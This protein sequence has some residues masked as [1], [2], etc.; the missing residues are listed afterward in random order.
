MR[1]TAMIA[2]ALKTWISLFFCLPVIKIIVVEKFAISLNKENAND[3]I[4]RLLALQAA[5][6]VV[7]FQS[8]CYG[9]SSLTKE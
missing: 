8:S 5:P 4:N 1:T 2:I 9:P 3:L 7:L 6:R